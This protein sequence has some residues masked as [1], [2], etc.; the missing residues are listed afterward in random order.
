MER[1][2]T[3]SGATS[4]V[5]EST[6]RFAYV[7]NGGIYAY[8]INQATGRLAAIAAPSAWASQIAV[9]PSG[10]FLYAMDYV[11]PTTAFAIGSDGSLAE[12]GQY[13]A[14][15]PLCIAASGRLVLYT[16][17]YRNGDWMISYA[18]DGDGGLGYISQ[19]HPG[20]LA[21][22]IHPSVNFAYATHS[23]GSVSRYTID[24][25]GVVEYVDD[26]DAG[27]T[28]SSIA[29]ESS[30]SHAYVTNAGS[31]SVSQYQIDQGTGA[32]TFVGDVASGTRPSCVTTISR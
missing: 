8:S 20:G 25:S 4:V 6:G 23:A 1:E 19:A 7:A 31:N 29:I 3:G 27:D 28:P 14:M 22:A 16:S 10:K 18:I 5:V 17:S 21:L 15:G 9:E 24:P 2:T 26:V 32:L 13:S 30:G 11:R 12:V